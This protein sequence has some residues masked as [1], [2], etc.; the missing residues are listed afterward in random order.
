MALFPP[1][2]KLF[3]E[4]KV[5]FRLKVYILLF[6]LDFLKK[7]NNFS[8]L[9]QLP[10]F[11]GILSG[12][13]TS[14][15]NLHCFGL[16]IPFDTCETWKGNVKPRVCMVFAEHTVPLTRRFFLSAPEVL[17]FFWRFH[18]SNLINLK[19]YIKVLYYG[20]RLHSSLQHPY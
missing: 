1:S 16:L 7:F 2:K 6:S 10:S 5:S 3:L 8:N 17:I 18:L 4:N 9:F 12:D 13:T 15:P 20:L 14:S 19:K 11:Q